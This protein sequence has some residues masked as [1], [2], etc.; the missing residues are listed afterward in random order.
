M[1]IK[2]PITLSAHNWDVSSPPQKGI[3]VGSITILRFGE[4]G[5]VGNIT[6]SL[7][8]QSLF[9]VVLGC[10]SSIYHPSR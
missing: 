2:D 3:I 8:L 5:F 7:M 1:F 4:P 6:N 9:E 10:V